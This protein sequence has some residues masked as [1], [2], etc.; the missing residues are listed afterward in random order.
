MRDQAESPGNLLWSHLHS[1]FATRMF[2]ALPCCR[3][4]GLWGNPALKPK[5][6]VQQRPEIRAPVALLTAMLV[7]EAPDVFVIEKVTRAHRRVH[8]ALNQF[9]AFGA[10][11]PLA[12]RRPKSALRLVE[13]VLWQNRFQRAF[14]N[15]LSSIA[16]NFE[17][18][19]QT[20][21]VLD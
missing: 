4:C 7:R 6:Q 13:Q 20:H 12:H 8:Q 5:T 1:L 19:R 18:T 15:V 14:Q 16:F 10:A 2:G 21:R 17:A 9:F 3:V 11:K